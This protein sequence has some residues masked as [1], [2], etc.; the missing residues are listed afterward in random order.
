VSDIGLFFVIVKTKNGEQVTVPSN[1]FI[2]K[3]IKQNINI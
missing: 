1:V 2:Q 3:M